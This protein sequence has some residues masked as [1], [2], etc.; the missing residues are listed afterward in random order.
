MAVIKIQRKKPFKQVYPVRGVF[1]YQNIALLL[2]FYH[3]MNFLF[4]T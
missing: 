3:R 1:I 2:A 4:Y